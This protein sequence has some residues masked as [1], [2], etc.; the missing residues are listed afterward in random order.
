MILAVLSIGSYKAGETV[1]VSWAK[2]STCH[3]EGPLRDGCSLLK[4]WEG[5]WVC[6]SRLWEVRA[7]KKRPAIMRIRTPIGRRHGVDLALGL[8]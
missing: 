3:Y 5:A 6:P 8:A 1:K 2:G 7:S 4:S